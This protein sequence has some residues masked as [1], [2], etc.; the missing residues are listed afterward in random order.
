MFEV[1]IFIQV[2]YADL[3][4]KVCVRLCVNLTGGKLDK[5]EERDDKRIGDACVC[6]CVCVRVRV[7]VCVVTLFFAECP[8]FLL[9]S[10]G[11]SILS[12]Q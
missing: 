9:A 1:G 11:H 5:A 2:G 10:M 8:I 3:F 12:A 6:V 4:I 7:R